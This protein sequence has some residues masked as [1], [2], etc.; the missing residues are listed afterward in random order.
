ME[1]L[2]GLTLVIVNLNKMDSK[3]AEVVLTI[4]IRGTQATR[5]CYTHYHKVDKDGKEING[6]STTKPPSFHD[7]KKTVKLSNS[8]VLGA[9][10]EPPEDKK[11]MN[12]R[13]WMSLPAPKR[14]QMHVNAYVRATHP[15]NRGYSVE[16]L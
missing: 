1:D 14:I 5:G 7:C 8:F 15:E 2:H 10:A 6:A 3:T 13:F 4:D 9:L 11:H 12:K 16:I